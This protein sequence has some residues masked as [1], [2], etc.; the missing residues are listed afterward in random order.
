MMVAG[1][2]VL[3][4]GFLALIA[5]AIVG[6]V[7][8]GMAPWLAALIVT[9]VMLIIGGALALFSYQSFKRVDMVPRQ[10]VETLGDAQGERDKDERANDV[11]AGPGC[12]P[13]YDEAVSADAP[14]E[15]MFTLDL[16]RD[17][18][19]APVSGTWDVGT[20]GIARSDQEHSAPESRARASGP[21]TA[22]TAHIRNSSP[23]A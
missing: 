11:G 14:T 15:A 5:F 12:E 4:A 9:L 3:Y 20:M 19:I 1:G 16:V 10:T 7:A 23:W 17:D 18:A 21:D 6:L 22:D 8:L 13:G 2:L